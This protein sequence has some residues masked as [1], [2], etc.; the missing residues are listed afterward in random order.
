MQRLIEVRSYK[1]K[2]GSGAKFHDL[3]V[4]QSMPLLDKFGTEV[5]AFGQSVHDPDAYFLVRAYDSLDHRRQ[6]QEAFYSSDAWRNGPRQS[7]VEL[8]D[9]DWDIVLWL[10]STA[11]DAMRNSPL[12]GKA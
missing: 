11:V 8:I 2:P 6:S 7:I 12:S 3:V 5:V 4:T 1:L 10:S 9:T